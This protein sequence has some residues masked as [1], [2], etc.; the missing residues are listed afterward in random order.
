MHH[1]AVVRIALF[2][3]KKSRLLV[4]RYA[5]QQ[6]IA[7]GGV[8]LQAFRRARA[9]VALRTNRREHIVL[10]RLELRGYRPAAA[11]AHGDGLS[12]LIEAVTIAG[13][14]RCATKQQ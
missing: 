3:T 8:E 7:V 11:A 14:T 2:H 6:V 13:A 12:I 4:A 1:V 5:D 9:D 10:D